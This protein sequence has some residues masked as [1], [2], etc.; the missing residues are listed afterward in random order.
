MRL[1]TCPSGVQAAHYCAPRTQL[2]DEKTPQRT[3]PSHTHYVPNT[4]LA[5]LMTFSWNATQGHASLT[6]APPALRFPV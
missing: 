3:T 1:L 5:M 2:R 4:K 6:A